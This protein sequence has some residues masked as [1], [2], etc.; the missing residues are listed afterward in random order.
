[1]RVAIKCH[2]LLVNH[3]SRG[4]FA[5]NRNEKASEAVSLGDNGF[6]IWKLMNGYWPKG[7]K[8]VNEPDGGK[9][10]KNKR[11]S[12]ESKAQVRERGGEMVIKEKDVRMTGEGHKKH[13]LTK[14]NSQ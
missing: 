10:G 12:E 7:L 14:V 8:C 6:S 4:T 1:M 2:I 13:G 9:R 3:T 5:P 11:S